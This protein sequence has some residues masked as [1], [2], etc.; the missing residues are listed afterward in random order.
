MPSCKDNFRS[1]HTLHKAVYNDTRYLLQLSFRLH[2]IQKAQTVLVTVFQRCIDEGY[3]SGTVSAGSSD[4]L[5]VRWI[6]VQ[7][8]MYADMCLSSMLR[9]GNGS[10]RHMRLL[11]EMCMPQIT[12]LEHGLE[13]YELRGHDNKGLPVQ[14]TSPTYKCNATSATRTWTRWYTQYNLMCKNL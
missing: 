5:T 8:Y 2:L 10:S 6:S 14:C 13:A 1:Q 9:V 7:T 11:S 4:A 3:F 12:E